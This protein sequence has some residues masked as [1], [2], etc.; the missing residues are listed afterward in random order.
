[1]E[2]TKAAL[3]ALEQSILKLE[4]A[5]Y[6]SKKAQAQLSEQ[7]SELKQAIKTTYERLDKAIENYDGGAE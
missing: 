3:T 7:V 2:Q 4:T 1:M 6:A 5:I